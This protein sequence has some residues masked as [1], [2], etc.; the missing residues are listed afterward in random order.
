MSVDLDN[1]LRG[2]TFGIQFVNKSDVQ[3]DDVMLILDACL[4]RPRDFPAVMTKAAVSVMEGSEFKKTTK[5]LTD[6][7]LAMRLVEL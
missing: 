1:R 5:C 6:S 2:R 3:D 7:K 4:V